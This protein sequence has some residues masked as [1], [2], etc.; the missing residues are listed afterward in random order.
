MLNYYLAIT[1]GP[2]IILG[3]N[4]LLREKTSPIFKRIVYRSIDSCIHLIFYSYF[5]GELGL[6]SKF[7][8]GWAFWTIFYFAT[9]GLIIFVPIGI[10]LRW[11]KKKS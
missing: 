2:L 7:D 10:Y 11:I 1:V 9:I 8:S 3:L 4:F 5:L 6:S